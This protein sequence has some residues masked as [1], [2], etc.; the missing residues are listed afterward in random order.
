MLTVNG[1]RDEVTSAGVAAV[2]DI[3]RKLSAA[4]GQSKQYARLTSFADSLADR[5]AKRLA[6]VTKLVEDVMV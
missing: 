6:I 5:D 1:D 2:R 4:M 3:G